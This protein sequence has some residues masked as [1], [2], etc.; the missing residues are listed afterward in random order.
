MRLRPGNLLRKNGIKDS[1]A[2]LF[3]FAFYELSDGQ[4]TKASNP[5]ASARK[6]ESMFSRSTVR[7]SEHTHSTSTGATPPASSSV[8]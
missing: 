4:V 5:G 2:V 6:A 1:A 3:G 8:S 7:T